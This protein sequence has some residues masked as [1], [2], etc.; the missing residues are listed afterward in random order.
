MLEVL[1]TFRDAGPLSPGDIA[2]KL[3]VPKYKALAMVSCM[4]ELGLLETV[5]SKGSYKIYRVSKL[6]IELLA[7]ADKGQSVE[8]AI[9]STLI[10]GVPSGSQAEPAEAQS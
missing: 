8:A 2:Q 1:R 7:K 6:G 10:E 9:S 3:G 4:H 5:Y